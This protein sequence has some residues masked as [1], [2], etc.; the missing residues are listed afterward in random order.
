LSEFVAEEHPLRIVRQLQAVGR[1]RE[2]GLHRVY[3]IRGDDDDKVGFAALK[4]GERLPEG[5]PN[6]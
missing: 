5:V 3:E 1:G 6:A 2:A 4:A